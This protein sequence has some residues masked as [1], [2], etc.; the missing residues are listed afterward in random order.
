MAQVAL[1]M[2]EITKLGL[3]LGGAKRSLLIWANPKLKKCLL[4]VIA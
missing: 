2:A 4:H 3:A 1:L